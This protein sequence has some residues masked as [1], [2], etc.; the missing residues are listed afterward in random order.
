ME[1]RVKAAPPIHTRLLA[2]KATAAQQQRLLDLQAHDTTLTRLHR[3]RQQLPERT[4]LTELQSELTEAKNRFMTLQREIDSQSADIARVE[5]DVETVRAR[6]E[7]DNLLLEKS[8]STKEVQALQSELETLARRQA[9]L[10]DRELELMEANEATQE[11]MAEATQALEAVEARRDELTQAISHAESQID[12]EV[13]ATRLERANIAAE[14]QRDL[15]DLYEQTRKQT[16]LGAARL[17]GNVSE[18]S[19]MA[20]APAELSNIRAAAPDDVV[21]CPQSGA[22]LIRDFD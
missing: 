19:N 7:R 14:L 13:E 16:G 21:F 15:L 9:E 3:R 4:A 20:L 17:R 12:E 1:F 18:G 22:I 10:E 2:M 8:S 5:D 11:Q 6:R